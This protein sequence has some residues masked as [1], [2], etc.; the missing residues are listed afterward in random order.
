MPA[1]SI[2]IKPAS[3]N[4]NMDCE[5]CFYKCLS[6]NREEYSKGFMTEETLEK[7]IIQAIDYAEGY[8]AFAF[9]GGEPTLAGIS[10]YKKAVELQKK[11]NT[12]NITIENTIQTNGMAIDEEWAKFLAKNNFLV[13]LSLDG[14]KK[15]HDRHRRDVQGEPTFERV[16]HTISLF[17]KYNVQYNILSVITNESATKASYLYNFY[18][19]NNFQFIQLI[20]CMDEQSRAD[21]GRKNKYAVNPQQYGQFLNDLFDLW[22]EDFRQ[23]SQM[24]IR[25]FSNLAQMAAGYPAEEC[26]MNGCCS[27]YF[28]VEGDGSVYPCDFYCLDEWKLGTVQ[29]SFRDLILADMAKKFIEDSKPVAEKCQTCPHKS[30]CRG[31]CRRWRETTTDSTIGLNYL[32][33]AY[34]IF[35]AHTKERINVLGQYI[36][37]QYGKY[38]P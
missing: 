8:V 25:M 1:A 3:A 30:L 21:S 5:Y 11:Y 37:K 4:C 32:C 29:N 24:D 14:P 18:K 38:T 12:K 34:D 20:P 13:G 2:L 10:F 31:G 33:P 35:F 15:I 27:C 22:Y 16:M 7:L 36:L 19:R 26:G 17:D 9:Q 28:V 6:S 23:G